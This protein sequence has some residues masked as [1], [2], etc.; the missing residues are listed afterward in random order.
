MLTN[1]TMFCNAIV[2]L[3]RNLLWEYSRNCV[4]NIF[5]IK[6]L[7]I[8]SLCLVTLVCECK[9]CNEEKFYTIY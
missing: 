7:S 1:I 5:K 2:I 4:I 9:K 3:N 6:H 8:A